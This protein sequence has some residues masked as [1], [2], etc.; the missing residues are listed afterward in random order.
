M[1]TEPNINDIKRWL[2]KELDGTIGEAEKAQLETW[3]K[4]SPQN[5]ALAQ[6]IHSAHFLRQAVLDSNKAICEKQWKS[7]RKEIGYTRRLHINWKSGIRMTAVMVLLAA[8][9]W[10][11]AYY[12]QQ[13]EE[14]RL[15]QVTIPA[16]STKAILYDYANDSIYR[17]PETAGYVF[18][19]DLYNRLV[20][21]PEDKDKASTYR[22]IVVPRG[23]EYQIRLTDSTHIHLGP[24][25]TLDIPL[26]Y[27]PRNRR[28]KMSGQA[29]LAVHP[30]AK[31]PFI[32]QTSDASIRVTGTRLNVEA[33]PD[34]PRTL[35]S[36]EQG[37]VELQA[38]DTSMKLT[39]GR[40]ASIGRDHRIALTTDSI[41]EHTSWHYSRMAFYNRTMEDIMKQLSRWYNIHADFDNDAARKSRI[42]MD[43]NKYETFNQLINDIEKM[44]E[45]QIKIKKENRVLISERNLE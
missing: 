42:T 10:M 1:P 21:V 6:R 8:F 28:I 9:G 13:Q 39:V 35:V 41:A 16:G 17:L 37:K 7:L 33:Y 5:E 11:F 45:L 2:L 23:G 15:A 29:F 44:N 43:V 27:S 3:K 36:L 25:S 26:D 40:T 12:L 34:A 30:D 32:I 19:L 14:S 20:S 22:S 4:E 24:E 31:H 18:E 38:G